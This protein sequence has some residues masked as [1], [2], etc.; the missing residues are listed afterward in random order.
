MLRLY[1]SKIKYFSTSSTNTLKITNTSF[2]RL[3]ALRAR[4]EKEE[5]EQN[6][7]ILPSTAAGCAPI[8]PNE[9][10]QLA[11]ASSTNKYQKKPDWLKI[12]T[13]TGERREN[14]DRLLS[15]V[16]KLNLATVCEEAKCPN[17]G[18]CWGGKD[19]TATAT[20]MLM[21]D[22]CTR[23]CHFCAVKTS[24]TPPPLDPEEPK[25]VAEAIVRWGL[26]Y[27]VLTSVDRDELLDQGAGHFSETVKRI[28]SAKPGILV[29]CLTPDFRGVE[30][31]VD[32]VVKSGL[33]VFAHNVET[34]ENEQRR[35]RDYRAGWNQSLSV[36]ARAKKTAQ[37]NKLTMLTKTSFMLGV[38]EKD[39]DLRRGL[40]QLAD[41]GVDV[42]TFGQ[43]L[44]PTPRHMPMDRYVTPEEFEA[45]KKE[46]MDL[47]FLYVA[48]GP[49]VRSSYKA[50]E[51]FLEGELKRRKALVEKDGV[52]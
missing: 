44:R 43:Y 2:T 23:G 10:E 34:T 29:E 16:K 48:S 28:K 1:L 21:G 6:V 25:R 18:E 4:L 22:T 51:Y 46:A 20:I 30:T 14:L 12:S 15:D 41:I 45:W 19:G 13:P 40:R 24:H 32:E 52:M 42:V 5:N 47:G 36:L 49:L 27:V 11:T 17:I 39:V 50:G 3:Q 35:V 9:L 37:D 7:P 26:G 33:D 31:C 38:G 8:L